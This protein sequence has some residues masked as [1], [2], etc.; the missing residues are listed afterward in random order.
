MPSGFRAL[1]LLALT[2]PLLRADVGVPPTL[3]TSWTPNYA[4]PNTSVQVR[5]DIGNPGTSTGLSGVSFSDTIPAGLSIPNIPPTPIACGTVS[6]SNGTVFYSNG[7][8][9]ANTP[10]VSSPCNF[11]INV[12]A[13]GEGA[14]V[15]TTSTISSNE[16]GSGSSS[17]ATLTVGVAPSITLSFSAATAAVGQ[18]VNLTFTLSN[19]NT[20][21]S[22]LGV[23][24][25]DSLPSGLVVAT[26]ANAT[27]NCGG[28]LT[29]TP[30]AGLIQLSGA[31]LAAN[32][33]CTVVVSVRPT[34][35]GIKNNAAQLTTSNLGN[36]NT[37]NSSLTATPAVGVPALSTWGM[38]LLTLLVGLIGVSQT[39]AQPSFRER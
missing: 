2:L 29:A 6:V 25:N 10:S 15:N 13:G 36:G 1:V 17:T 8:I 4:T 16:G 12:L 32:A 39:K 33:N 37:A 11:E 22:A 20:T 5:F 3:T 34:S 28:N 26:P 19:S 31:G 9:P 30:G 18:S 35:T 14:Y 23:G 38:V 24:F 21:V 27:N 7:L